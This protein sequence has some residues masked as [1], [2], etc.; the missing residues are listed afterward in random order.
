MVGAGECDD[1]FAGLLHGAVNV[2]A[3]A[4]KVQQHLQRTGITPFFV[5]SEMLQMCQHTSAASNDTSLTCASALRTASL[6]LCRVQASTRRLMSQA[7]RHRAMDWP[8]L[9]RT[10]GCSSSIG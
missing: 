1:K 7:T 5:K 2:Y 9:K 6:G 8:S 4:M 3:C 10:A